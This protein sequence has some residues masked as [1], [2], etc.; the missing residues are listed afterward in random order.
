MNLQRTL[1]TFS[2]FPSA[3]DTPVPS[4]AHGAEIQFLFPF[5]W[6]PL[7]DPLRGQHRRA[8]CAQHSSCFDGFDERRRQIQ[9][10]D[11]EAQGS[12]AAVPVMPGS[13]GARSM[14]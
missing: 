7:N 4:S 11:L 8:S 2:G 12:S 6:V 10:R 13:R 3:T 5:L 9:G 14:P 1:K